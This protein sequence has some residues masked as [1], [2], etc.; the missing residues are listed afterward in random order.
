MLRVHEPQGLSGA[1]VR[2]PQDQA[3]IFIVADQGAVDDDVGCI[4]VANV[5]MPVTNNQRIEWSLDLSLGSSHLDR[6]ARNRAK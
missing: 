3:S 6:A 2:R 4:V 1:G 5:G